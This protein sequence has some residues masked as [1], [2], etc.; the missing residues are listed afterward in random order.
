MK[1]LFKILVT[2]T[3]ILIGG[4]ILF[5]SCKNPLKPVKKNDCCHQNDSCHVDTCHTD[6]NIIK[7]GNGLSISTSK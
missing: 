2:S 3:F 1:N 6:T 4:S 5:N 7:C